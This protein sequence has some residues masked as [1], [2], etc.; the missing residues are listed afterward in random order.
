MS[1]VLKQCVAATDRVFAWV[2]RDVVRDRVERF[3]VTAAVVGLAAHL[4]VIALSRNAPQIAQSWFGGLDRNYLH[5]VYTPFS[6]ILFYEVLLLVLSLPRSHTTSIIKQYEIVSLIVIRRVFKDLGAFTNLEAWIEEQD[7]AVAV[8]YDMLGA[9]AMF[10]IVTAFARSRRPQVEGPAPPADLALFV[11]MKRAI[12][13]LLGVLL[14]GLAAW[15]VAQWTASLVAAIDAPGTETK[16]L[17]MYFFPLFFEV[18]IFTDVF[19]LIIS[20]AFYDK[21]ELVFRNAAFVLSTVLLRVSITSPRP[22][23]LGLGLLAMT[24]GYVILVLFQWFTPPA[25]APREA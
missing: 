17:D 24:Y 23:D 19:L 13:L 8:L 1:P 11:S 3:F 20:I 9:A 14:V 18:M 10:A 16:E 4:A 25:E 7:A 21:Y 5:A 6:F 2:D 12:A 22:Y 15:S